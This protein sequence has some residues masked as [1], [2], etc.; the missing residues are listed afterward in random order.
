MIRDHTVKGRHLDVKK[1]ISKADMDKMKRGGPSPGSSPSGRGDYRGYRDSGRGDRN[2]DRGGDL[3]ERRDSW[4]NGGSGGGWSNGDHWVGGGGGSSSYRGMSPIVDIYLSIFESNFFLQV[5]VVVAAVVIMAMVSGRVRIGVVIKAAVLGGVEVLQVMDQ[6]RVIFNSVL[7]LKIM[8]IIVII[9]SGGNSW[10]GDY[11]NG[12]GG[13]M[14]EF[15]QGGGPV[16]NSYV[17]ERS[18]PYARDYG[19][20]I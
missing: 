17:T 9:I 16:R 10:G 4:S 15:S 11:D 19:G 20:N 18:V 14:R 1:A 5:E 12:Y 2:V 8:F 13:N 3:W 6:A 7:R